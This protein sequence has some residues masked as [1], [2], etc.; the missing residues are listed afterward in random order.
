MT[1]L[2]PVLAVEAIAVALVTLALGALLATAASRSLHADL[3]LPDVLALAVPAVSA[4]AFVLELAHIAARGHVFSEPWLV[5][6]LT[7]G[8]ALAAAAAAVRKRPALGDRP[9]WI[10]LAVVSVAIVCI[11][12]SPVARVVPLGPPGS[13][14]GMHAGWASQLLNGETTPSASISGPIPNAYPWEFHAVLATI[15]VLTPG[16]RP[17]GALAPMQLVQTA[18]AVFA[19]FALG[20]RVAGRLGPGERSWLGGAATAVL[21]ALAGGNVF[22]LLGVA[23]GTPRAG[24]PRGTYTLSSANLAPPVARDLGF[25][26]FVT[27]LFLLVLAAGARR[28][29][30]ALGAAGTVLG[31]A[32]VTSPEF[33]FVGAGA[34]VLVVALTPEMRRLRGLAAVFAPALA[35]L[36]VWL[37]PLVVSYLRVGGFVD[38][39]V[40]PAIRLGPGDIPLSWALLIPLAAYG[41]AVSLARARRRRW[42]SDAAALVTLGTTVVAGLAVLV[43]GLIPRV[44]GSGFDILGRASRYWPI[45]E[46]GVAVLAAIG[47]TDLVE[48]LAARRVAA[49][50]AVAAA[51]LAVEVPLP[52]AASIDLPM[53]A[54]RTP[55]LARALLD[56]GPNAFTAPGDT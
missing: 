17:Y 27:V 21:G 30:A 4:Y 22:V 5:R 26:L 54:S 53:Q 20:R 2:F 36:A 9:T 28:R 37:V 18:G 6:G 19:L 52:V 43:S 35:I 38:A 11:W 39:T 47:V 8:A 15:A 45:L 16:G 42:V 7:V 48:R 34:A 31:L 13:D 33:L 50:V 29:W 32:A 14:A 46:L 24:G 44:L 25:V 12:G 56:R 49:A 51:V 1:G 55:G 10:A 3:D 40:N 23:A 41:I